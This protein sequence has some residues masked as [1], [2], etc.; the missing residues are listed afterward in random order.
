MTEERKKHSS[1]ETFKI[2]F[3]AILQNI[4]CPKHISKIIFSEKSL[5]VRMFVCLSVPSVPSVPSRPVPE[6]KTLKQKI[7]LNKVVRYTSRVTKKYSESCCGAGRGEAKLRIFDF[8]T[9]L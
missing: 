7:L 4:F 3:Y 6:K 8:K 1:F 5:S 2:Y 9:T